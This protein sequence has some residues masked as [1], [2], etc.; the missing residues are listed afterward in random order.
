MRIR[1]SRREWIAANNRIFSA[2]GATGSLDGMISSSVAE[3]DIVLRELREGSAD[4]VLIFAHSNGTKIYMPGKSGSSISLAEL[5]AMKRQTAPDRVVVLVAC[6][7]GA[8]N[9]DTQSLAEAL[10]AG[11]LAR[12][13]FAY[14]GAISPS[15]VPEML[16]RLRSG[17]SLRS[18]LSGLYQI[19]TLS[20]RIRHDKG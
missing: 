6:D 19:V 3:K 20:N 15:Y 10:L 17:I 13:V 7:A 18:A 14:P 4:V 9:K 16:E 2:L 12:T 8:V 1:G 11:K 5:S